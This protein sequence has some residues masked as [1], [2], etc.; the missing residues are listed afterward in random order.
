MLWLMPLVMVLLTFLASVSLSSGEI[1]STLHDARKVIQMRTTLSHRLK[2]IPTH[3]FT[4][5]K[6]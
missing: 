3:S 5:R 1:D 2:H 6:L 4:F